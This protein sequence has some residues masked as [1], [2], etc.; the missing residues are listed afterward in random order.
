MNSVIKKIVMSRPYSWAGIILLGILANILVNNGLFLGSGILIDVSTA[1]IAWIAATS[2]VEFFHRK[3]DGR[4]MTSPIFPIF[5]VAFFI[6]ISVYNNVLTLI[7]IVIIIVSDVLYSMK[8]K[9]C[10]FSAF[11]FM[12]RGV[13][14]VCIFLIILLFHSY[15]NI[16]EVI[17]FIVSIYLFTNS[18]NLIGDIRDVEFDKYTFPRRFGVTNSYVVAA[19]LAL[20]PVIIIP[21]LM[22]TLPIILSL[23]TIPIV[24]N[25][26]SL[27]RIFVLTTIFFYIN[28]IIS[29]L[30]QSL[31]LLNILFIGVLLNFTYDSVPRKSNPK[32]A[33]IYNYQ[34]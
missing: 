12:I 2:I 29:I 22:I 4:G 28:Y 15:Y 10:F 14:E 34:K 3:I 5:F 30:N 25:A 33:Q 24:R 31:I 11:S 7:L 13:L 21:N 17:P 6:I 27:H 19:I 1:F 18:R 26:Y 20:I 9:D 8:I 32:S 23:L 16:N